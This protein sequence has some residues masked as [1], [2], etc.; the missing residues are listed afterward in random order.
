MSEVLSHSCG[1]FPRIKH[2]DEIFFRVNV[3]LFF[4]GLLN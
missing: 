3:Y 2:E 4:I 1:I